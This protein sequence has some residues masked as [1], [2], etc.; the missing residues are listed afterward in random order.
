MS[1]LVQTVKAQ[2]SSPNRS[3]GQTL[4]N[5]MNGISYEWNPLDTLKMVSASSVFGEPAYYRDGEFSE[6]IIRDEAAGTD[7]EFADYVIDALHEF[8]GLKTSEIMEKA[9]DA[10]LD[11]DFRATLEWAVSL[12]KEYM[13][14]L[15]PQV[16]MVR[17]AVHPARTRF[18]KENPGL[19][20]EINMQ[21]MERGD[22]PASQLAYYLYKNKSKSSIPN[23]LKKSWAKKLESLTEYEI[24]KYRNSG[25]GMI[26]TVRIC[27]GNNE[28][29]NTLMRTGTV[30]VSG[31]EFTWE[32]LRAEGKPWLEILN[33]VSVGHMAMLRNLRGIFTEV[34]NISYARSILA[35][36][37][38]GVPDGKQLPFRYCSAYEAIKSAPVNHKQLIL[39]AL[40]ECIDTACDNMPKLRGRTA[41]LSDNSGSAWGTCT[42]EY[43]TVTVASIGNL[44]SVITARNS[45]E[46]FVIKFGDSLKTYDVSKRT[47]VLSQAA[48]ISESRGSDIG[49][50]TECGLW[51]FFRNAITQK[52]YYNNIF[53][54]SDM[55][56]GHG[57]L[58]GISEEMES[59]RN[60]GFAT[61]G[62]YIDVNSLV[63]EYRRRVNPKVNVYCIQTAGYSSVVLPENGYRIALLYG[64]TGKELLYADAINR[65]WDEKE[66]G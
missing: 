4:V 44:S 46:G 7:K 53:I 30:P 20:A 10:A 59:Y 50:G 47:G 33:S 3:E 13:M 15:N 61:R 55:Q 22:E 56:A 37:K 28:K 19:F 35:K 65:F 27:H 14:R 64:W 17:A 49:T 11:Y 18:T 5:F 40:E 63:K 43:G 9:I 48:E 31:D 45:E 38:A 1:K 60:M 26:D 52:Q 25:I 2:K 62:P 6:M 29:I 39:D 51:L 21:I 58:Y 8:D 16:I 66:K 42:S 12:R 24:Y 57:D 36:L 54:Y 23:I 32:K 41:C 34:N